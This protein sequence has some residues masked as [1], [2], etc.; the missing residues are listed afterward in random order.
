MKLRITFMSWSDVRSTRCGLK[1]CVPAGTSAASWD[2]PAML[3]LA[4]RTGDTEHPLFV[5]VVAAPAVDLFTHSSC[6][7]NSPVDKEYHEPRAIAQKTG[8]CRFRSR[9][10]HAHLQ[11]SQFCCSSMLSANLAGC[12]SLARLLVISSIGRDLHV[13]PVSV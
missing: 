13:S 5:T 4:D 3:I 2:P 8:V 9:L 11:L 12:S 1:S 7:R 10:V 6:C